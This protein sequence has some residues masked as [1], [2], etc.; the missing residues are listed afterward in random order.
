[1]ASDWQP[2]ETAPRDGTPFLAALCEPFHSNDAEGW[3]PW[4]D[5]S[6]VIAWWDDGEFRMCFSY[7]GSCDTNGIPAGVFY[8]HLGAGQITHW[9]PLPKPPESA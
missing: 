2:I 1:M 9:Q 4:T 7:E 8:H 5:I 3:V 6:T